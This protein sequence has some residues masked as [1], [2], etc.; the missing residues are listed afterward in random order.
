MS[1]A[2]PLAVKER[3]TTGTGG[4]REERRSGFTP[5]VLYGDKKDPVSLSVEERLLKK[6]L[7]EPGIFSHL[8]TIKVGKEDQ[9]VLIRDIQFHPVTDRP[10]HVD[11]LRVSKS[12]TIHVDVPLSFLN[13]EKCPGLKHGGVM[14]ILRHSL[15][16][17]CAP[18]NIPEKIEIDLDGK[19]IGYS[20]SL[21]SLELPAGVKV[22][23]LEKVETVLT[24]V[25]PKVKADDD[26]D[27]NQD[28]EGD[29]AEE[30]SDASSAE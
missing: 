28:G 17:T 12:S 30:G 3:T 1:S 23:H 8:F 10:M 13:E 20:F 11:F 4:A 27:D 7:L 2:R 15:H 9:K 26:M 19:E 5:A 25:P 14:N 16:V 24:I 6:E 22:S 21:D 29:D 18:T